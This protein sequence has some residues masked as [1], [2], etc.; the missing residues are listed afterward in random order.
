VELTV[1][2]PQGCSDRKTQIRGPIF[3]SQRILNCALNEQIR[4]AMLHNVS[5]KLSRTTKLDFVKLN[6][7]LV[8]QIVLD[9]DVRL[10]F[11]RG[12]RARTRPCTHKSRFISAA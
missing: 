4:C 7:S 10:A 5:L 11:S 2:H 1:T 9:Y 12:V 8:E 6:S 3:P